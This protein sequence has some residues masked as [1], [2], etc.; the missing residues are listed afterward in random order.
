MTYLDGDV[1]RDRFGEA[2]GIKDTA[3]G[4]IRDIGIREAA[5]MDTYRS[6]VGPRA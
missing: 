1:V 3:L 2:V 6:P 4:P 5:R